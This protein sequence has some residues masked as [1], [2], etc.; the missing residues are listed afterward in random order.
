MDGVRQADDKSVEVE[1]ELIGDQAV[2]VTWTP[3]DGA[4]HELRLRILSDDETEYYGTGE[5]FQALNQ[6]GYILPMRVDDRYGNKGVGTHK[7]IPFFISSRGFGVW[8]DVFDYVPA[9]AGNPPP[10]TAWEMASVQA[11]RSAMS[12]HG[13]PCG[14]A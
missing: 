2:A 14:P 1:I 5:R 3:R 10:V 12:A 8:V 13:S 11:A 7:P 6:R 9:F 4:V